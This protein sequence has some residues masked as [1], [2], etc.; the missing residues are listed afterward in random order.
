M[1]GRHDLGGEFARDEKRAVGDDEVFIVEVGHLAS[2]IAPCLDTRCDVSTLLLME[3]CG[4]TQG[5]GGRRPV[6]NNMPEFGGRRP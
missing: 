2:W 5:D 1:R 3:G 4:R 6:Q